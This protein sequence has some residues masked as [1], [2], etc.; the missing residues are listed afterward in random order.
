MVVVLVHAQ[1]AVALELDG[2]LPGGGDPAA[3]Y[4]DKESDVEQRE[5]DE[6]NRG[7]P[8]QDADGEVDQSRSADDRREEGVGSPAGK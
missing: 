3:D 4:P 2:P 1:G 7:W 5:Q 6:L 8:V